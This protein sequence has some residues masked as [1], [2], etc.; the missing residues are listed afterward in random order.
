MP[1]RRLWFGIGTLPHLDSQQA[2]HQGCL[3][4]PTLCPAL[5]TL[6]LLPD[7]SWELEKKDPRGEQGSSKRSG[8]ACGG[9]E[10]PFCKENDPPG[11]QEAGGRE[12]VGAS[13]LGG[14]GAAKLLIG[15]VLAFVGLGGIYAG[16]FWFV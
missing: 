4:L 11:L 9:K 12:A 6:V 14:Q 16:R 10:T 8:R 3:P 1:S 2:P 15:N 7:S 13:V 5:Q